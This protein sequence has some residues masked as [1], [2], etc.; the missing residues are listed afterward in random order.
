VSLS[1]AES[2]W[3][4]KNVSLSKAESEW[5]V[6][7]EAGKEI[8]YLC[9]NLNDLGFEQVSTELLYEDSRSVIV[10]TENPVNRKASCHIDTHKHF[11]GQLVEI[12]DD[13][14]GVMY[15]G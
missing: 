3:Y 1:K 6:S 10:M 12:Q 4:V 14:V 2:E 7:S 13:R 15:D 9:S 5:Y 8:V 11:I